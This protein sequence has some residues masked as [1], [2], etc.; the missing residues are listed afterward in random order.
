MENM[1]ENAPTTKYK[2]KKKPQNMMSP[3]E[4][5]PPEVETHPPTKKPELASPEPT[6]R[7]IPPP[8]E[9]KQKTLPKKQK[10]SSEKIK[11]LIEDED[12]HF[13]VKF[14]VMLCIVLVCIYILGVMVS[15]KNASPIEI[16]TNGLERAQNRSLELLES[17]KK[18]LFFF[19]VSTK[20]PNSKESNSNSQNDGAGSIIKDGSIKDTKGNS[21]INSQ[22][23]MYKNKKNKK[24]RVSEKTVSKN[25]KNRKKRVSEKTDL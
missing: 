13:N 23:S 17:G 19:S 18:C 24:K 15:E 7:S 21:N 9:I 4:K 10:I 20:E 22:K 12:N 2:I 25:K 6:E 8:Q 14:M 5:P 16:M 3:H 1:E 11:T